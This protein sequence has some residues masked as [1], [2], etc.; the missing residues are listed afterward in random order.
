[1]EEKRQEAQSHA[2]HQRTVLARSQAMYAVAA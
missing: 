2:E 1:M